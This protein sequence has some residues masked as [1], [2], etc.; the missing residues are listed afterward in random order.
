MNPTHLPSAI[1][2]PHWG[3]LFDW[4]GVI[5]DSKALHEAAW[6][7]VAREFGYPHG[8]DD[9]RRHFGS[10]NRR[11]IAEILGW[12][13]DDAQIERIAERKE[14][15]YRERLQGSGDLLLPGV[16]AFLELLDS[17]GIPRVVVSSSPRLNIDRV[18]ESTGLANFQAIVA[19]E[20]TSRGKPDPQ[21]FLS[22]AQRLGVSKE[23]CVVFEDA[24]AGIEAGRRGG[25]RVVALTTTHAAAELGGAD[26][27][28]DSLEP[29]LFELIES[30]FPRA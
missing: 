20:D 29:G 13:Q 30:W 1:T 9:F 11:A 25:M 5:I 16:K 23:R 4:D 21:G 15:L 7:Q 12:T 14:I 26:V 2:A 8:P 3:A 10:Q 19:A 6:N 22:G 28:V 27:V 24:P 18:L 17:R